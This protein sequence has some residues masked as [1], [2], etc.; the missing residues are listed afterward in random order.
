[1][2]YRSF[3]LMCGEV[4]LP[5]FKLVERP[6]RASVDRVDIFL[7]DKW[8]PF[9]P[10]FLGFVTTSARHGYTHGSG[11]CVDE[12]Y[13]NPLRPGAKTSYESMIKNCGYCGKPVI[14]DF[15]R[16]QDGNIVINRLEPIS[17]YWLSIDGSRFGTIIEPY[18]GAKCSLDKY[19]SK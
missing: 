3:G 6:G 15:P 18:C 19:E 11:N 9:Y 12:H 17:K 16:D 4:R 5:S 13:S 10:I 1:M 2:L 7:H 14:Y 8:K